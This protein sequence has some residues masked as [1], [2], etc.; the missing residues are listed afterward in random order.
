MAYTLKFVS[1]FPLC[2]PLTKILMVPMNKDSEVII[3]ARALQY[4]NLALG[5]ILTLNTVRTLYQIQ[6]GFIIYT[7][8]SYIG[9]LL[10]PIHF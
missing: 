10:F 2:P 6:M 8:T 4:V 3:R 7:E 9:V 5:K 1:K